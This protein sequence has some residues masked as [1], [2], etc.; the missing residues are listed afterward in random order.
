MK[1]ILFCKKPFDWFFYWN[2][3]FVWL[4]NKK[5]EIPVIHAN[6]CVC[7][8]LEQAVVKEMAWFRDTALSLDKLKTIHLD[9]EI[10]AEQLY[11]QKVRI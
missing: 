1:K 4:N 11:E 2:C 7:Y 8:Q 3:I 9:P 6:I 5:N 10:I